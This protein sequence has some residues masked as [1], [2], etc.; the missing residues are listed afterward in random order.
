MDIIKAVKMKC[1]VV[2]NLIFQDKNQLKNYAKLSI[3]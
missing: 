1:S 3:V 2:V